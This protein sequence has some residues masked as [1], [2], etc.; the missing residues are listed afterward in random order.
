MK[1]KTLL[2]M[3][4]ILILGVVGAMMAAGINYE[5]GKVLG[6]DIDRTLQEGV[7]SQASS[8]IG[9]TGTGETSW[10]VGV[11]EDPR[12]EVWMEAY[13]IEDNIMELTIDENE[14]STTPANYKWDMVV[15]TDEDGLN[16]MVEDSGGGFQYADWE[17]LY[18]GNVIDEGMNETWCNG[19]NG[20]ILFSSGGKNQFP[21]TFRLDLSNLTTFE[22]YAG[23]GSVVVNATGSSDST[24]YSAQDHICRTSNGDLH[25]V[26]QDDG[27]DL[28]YQHSNDSGVNWNASG[29][30][31]LTGTVT[32]QQVVCTPND[33]IYAMYID[34]LDVD[35]YYSD[36]N[37]DSF[38]GPT[39]VEDDI[40][41]FYSLSCATDSNSVVHCCMKDS[42]SD[43]AYVNTSVLNGG[44]EVDSTDTEFCDIAVDSDDNLYIVRTE[45]G[46]DDL[47]IFQS[48][49]GGAS[50]SSE[51]VDDNLGS[52]TAYT[53]YVGGPS[54]DIADDGTIYITSIHTSDLQ[55]CY[56]TF[57]VSWACSELD[58]TTSYNP[59]IKVSEK[60][61][62]FI[63]YQEGTGIANNLYILNSSNGTGFELVT[64]YAT[65][66]L[67]G[68]ARFNHD[69]DNGL[70][71]T[72]Y[73]IYT[74]DNSVYFDS[75]AIAEPEV[76][77]LNITYP[78]TSNTLTTSNGTDETFYFNITDLIYGT[79]ITS[80]V[81]IE[82]ITINGEYATIVLDDFAGEGNTGAKSPTATGEDHND[83]NNP[84]YAYSSDDNRADAPA[85][86][87]MQ[88]YYNFDFTIPSGS[89]I[90]GIE[91]QIE[92][93]Y[94]N[95]GGI[96]EY[97][98][99]WN[100]GTSYTTAIVDEDMIDG[101]DTVI[102]LGNSTWL[103]G[104]SWA[105]TEFTDANFRFRAERTLW[106]LYID[107]INITV[108]YNDTATPQQFA[109]N[110]TS[111]VVNVTVP[112]IVDGTYDLFIN[113]TYD[114]TTYSET[115]TSAVIYGE[116]AD[117]CTYSSGDWVVDC[118]DNCAIT[119]PVDVGGNDIYITGT[120]TFETDSDITNYGKL[121][122]AGTDSSNRCVVSCNGGCFKT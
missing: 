94:N 92:G 84:T 37:G 102:T 69:S 27:S 85:N 2:M 107:N 53:T 51:S 18:Y 114:G 11:S 118:S 104:R 24:G 39:T 6:S 76:Y 7:L 87:D 88:D 111:W 73:F 29:G 82:N 66:G 105:D 43:L 113:A 26:F 50:W 109:H 46:T 72:L 10:R 67:G 54:L 106:V 55:Y 34:G 112:D 90:L 78:I 38:I 122:L 57:G 42:S 74:D 16:Y 79:E 19:G 96:S 9:N 80:D 56:G 71:D 22:L 12:E 31:L 49:D 14:F 17:A 83:F 121:V 3:T 62:I 91:V 13:M 68:I 64:T 81:T 33:Y 20:Y 61:D 103:W 97:D 58:S 21:K 1:I 4:G 77:S 63:A 70:N 25:T 47:D 35:M 93:K 44:Y 30:E 60:Q 40:A 59:H 99:S 110:G 119:S 28:W 116:A 23:T 41:S 36:D 65:S 120:G 48:T 15:C 8:P 95:N 117:S 115:E 52:V 98:L 45:D 101:S 32:F 100:G 89:D 108:Y 5:I 86:G 75:F